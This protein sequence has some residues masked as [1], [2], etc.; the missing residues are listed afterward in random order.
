MEVRQQY[1]LACFPFSV[2]CRIAVFWGMVVAIL[3]INFGR[4]LLSL[5]MARYITRPA[6]E[7]FQKIFGFVLLAFGERL[8]L[9]AL[10]H[11]G[12]ITVKGL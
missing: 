5:S 11:L 3:V 7:A 9:G 1:H 2:V 4:M 8:I 12:I 10:M 6:L